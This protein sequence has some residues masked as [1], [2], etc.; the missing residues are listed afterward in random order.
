MST[1]PDWTNNR[2]APAGHVDFAVVIPCYRVRRHILDVLVAVG[3][4]WGRIFVVD[5]AC[6]GQSGRFVQDNITD[7]RVQSM[8]RINNKKVGGAKVTG[9]RAALAA[10][11]WFIARV[12]GDGQMD[13]RLLPLLA[14][15]LVR[16]EA[17][18]A[19]GN[20]FYSLYNVRKM[21]RLRLFGNAVLSFITKLSSGYWSIFDP[22]NGFTVIHASALGRLELSDLSERYFFESDMLAKL[23]GIRAV[24]LDVPMEAVYGDE[25]SNLRIRRVLFEFLFKHAREF[26][27]RVLYSYFLRDFNIASLQ[28]VFGTILFVFGT[29]FGTVHW[30]RSA[31]V[32]VP[33]TAGTVLVAALPVLLG[34]QLL[35][36]FVGYDIANEPRVPLQRLAGPV[37]TPIPPYPATPG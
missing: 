21:P 25:R 24:T 17:D 13:P 5:G 18:Y 28:L 14:A 16:S 2:G 23:G 33:A 12:D 19:K 30:V 36:S 8:F 29:V 6:P 9:C 20:R 7:P 22:T 26:F 32:G 1:P 27:K 31:T 10:G 37:P 11:A 35:L 34:F 4:E 15:P 3:P